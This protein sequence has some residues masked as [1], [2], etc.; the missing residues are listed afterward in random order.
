MRHPGLLRRLGAERLHSLA[1][2]YVPFLVYRVEIVNRAKR[3]TH[4][5]ALDAVKGT[6]DPYAFPRVPS[7]RR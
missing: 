5:L 1:D 6:L 4:C 3:E 2:A 7:P